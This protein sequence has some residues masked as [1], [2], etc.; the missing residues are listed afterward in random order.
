MNDIMNKCL[1]ADDKFMLEIHLRQSEFI[2][3]ACG[4]FTKN[5]Q[6]IQK[7]KETGESSSICQDEL[8]KG[9]YQHDMSYGDYNDLVRR[10]ASDKV[11]YHKAFNTT[12]NP[13]YDEYQR[14]LASMVYKYFNKKSEVVIMDLLKKG[15]KES[16]ILLN[17]KHERYKE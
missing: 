14:E 8:D 11:L 6:R 17:N 5:I 15:K 9:C 16:V 4:A 10:T 7:F 13:L 12:K 3:S 2:Y 1:V